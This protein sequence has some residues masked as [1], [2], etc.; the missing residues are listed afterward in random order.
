MEPLNR[1]KTRKRVREVDKKKR[2]KEQEETL[3]E[4]EVASESAES[5]TVQQDE[6]EESE[7]SRLR[8]EAEDYKRKWYS[9]SAEY[10]NYRKRTTAES[11][12][13]YAEGRSDVVSKLFPI[14]DNLERAYAA[15][16]DEA[17][18][19]GISMVLTSFEALLKE[20]KIE[21]ID[22]IG[23]AF[24]AEKCEAIMA[25]EAQEGEE[26]GR[27][28]QVYQK[29]YIRNGKVLRYAQVVVIK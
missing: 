26:S 29:G 2:E 25:V 21:T 22:P 28:K 11:A 4:K 18:R 7:T 14:A 6:T 27:V 5:E 23:E 16:A 10:E 19:K 9:V 17:T 24:D 8:A 13:R 3:E 20:E 15:C 1:V 12:R